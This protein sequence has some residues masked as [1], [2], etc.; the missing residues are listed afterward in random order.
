MRPK[1]RDPSLLQALGDPAAARFY[2]RYAVNA[3]RS[4]RGLSTAQ[5]GDGGKVAAALADALERIARGERAQSVLGLTRPAH[6]PKAS[7]IDE[8]NLE[9]AVDYWRMRNHGTKA[10]VARQKVARAWGLSVWRVTK[11]AASLRE[12]AL[13]IAAE[14][15]ASGRDSLTVEQRKRLMRL[16]RRSQEVR[17]T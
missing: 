2:L 7:W 17:K 3:L 1:R 14:R 12:R 5:A 16:T 11:I 4:E 15:E 10:S 9:L 6:R 8:R 13:R